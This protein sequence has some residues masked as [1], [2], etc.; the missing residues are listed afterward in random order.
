MSRSRDPYRGVVDAQRARQMF[1]LERQEPHLTLKPWIEAY[2]GVRWELPEG[3]THHQTIVA[4]TTIHVTV[5]TEAQTATWLY[6]VPG[7]A[8][9]RDITGTGRVFGVKFRA[10]AFS[11]WCDR[12]L[13]ALYNR[14]VPLDSLWGSEAVEWAHSISAE[15]DF[16]RR[17]ALAD[18]YLLAKPRTGPGEGYRCAVRMFDD[19]SLLKVEDAC[20]VLG[21]D[22]RSLQRLFSREVGIGPKELLSRYR[23]LEAAQR[24]VNEPELPGTTLA[25][26][27]GYADQAHFIRDFRSVTGVSPEAYRRR[28]LSAAAGNGT[29]D[30][31]GDS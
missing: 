29:S 28:G 16:A 12:P 4:D 1:Q 18:D 31:Q 19:D 20:A 15:D 21:H 14:R 17:G 26:E 6:G 27:L 11:S 30:P 10:G 25:A 8:F 2:W 9:V 7:P 24:I 13:K 5:E 3:T 22:I 23:L